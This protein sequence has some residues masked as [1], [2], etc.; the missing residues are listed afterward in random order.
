MKKIGKFVLLAIFAAGSLPVFG[1]LAV[2]LSFNRRRYMVH[3]HI[4]ACVTIRND[5]GKPLLFGERPELQGFVLF[6]IRDERGL[7]VKRRSGTEFSV[8]GLYIAPGEVKRIVIP[9]HR[10]YDLSR[11]GLYRIHAYVSHNMVPHEYRSRDVSIR[12][13][14]GVVIWEKTVGVPARDNGREWI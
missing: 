13:S 5:S 7:L 8:T 11:S 9:L 6:D 10:Y 3:E 2:S 4:Y 1:Q 12:L 14:P